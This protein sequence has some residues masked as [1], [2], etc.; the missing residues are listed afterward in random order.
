MIKVLGHG[1]LQ[2]D[3]GRYV[4]TTIVP[5]GIVLV[6]VE[7]PNREL[8]YDVALK[9]FNYFAEYKDI[10][11]DKEKRD[12]ISSVSVSV[13]KDRCYSIDIDMEGEEVYDTSL[14]MTTNLLD[15]TKVEYVIGYHHIDTT[16]KQVTNGIVGFDNKIQLGGGARGSEVEGQ[17]V[18]NLGDIKSLKELLESIYN[19]KELLG[20]SNQPIIVFVL[21]CMV[22]KCNQT[23]EF[24][25]FTRY[26][27]ISRNNLDK[28]QF[29]YTTQI[30]S[31][32]KYEKN[33]QES[34]KSLVS[35]YYNK[36]IDIGIDT[37]VFF[38][39]NKGFL[40]DII[41]GLFIEDD[42]IKLSSLIALIRNEQQTWGYNRNVA[43]PNTQNSVYTYIPFK[44]FVFN[45]NR[46]FYLLHLF[47]ESFYTDVDKTS[48]KQYIFASVPEDDKDYISSLVYLG[49]TPLVFNKQIITMYSFEMNTVV[50]VKDIRKKRA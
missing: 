7:E 41:A 12:G 33:T 9:F 45:G 8:E 43:P 4:K 23:L 42:G 25:K 32:Q 35:A 49:Y 1:A 36:D 16:L 10:F 5:K 18:S 3:Y 21:S 19:I 47:L 14:N 50:Y 46:A 22:R 24:D 38:Y 31:L 29:V 34:V 44:P 37:K 26:S 15:N 6:T 11:N 39:V 17:I 2:Y 28:K 40:N 27:G 13:G 48:M 20:L 30:E